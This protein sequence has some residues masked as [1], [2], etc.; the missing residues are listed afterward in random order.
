LD[1]GKNIQQSI[2][3]YLKNFGVL[4]LAGLVT[5]LI[6]AFSFGILA[7][8]M[9]A[10]LLALSFKLLRG[11]KGEFN[12]IFAHFNKFVPTFLL[13]LMLAVVWILTSVIG[14]IPLIGFLFQLAVGPAL[15]LIFML[16]IAL[17][18][19]KD[20]KPLDALKQGLNYF[21]TNPLMNWLYSLVIGILAGVGGIAG[22][23]LG[24][25]FIFIMPFISPFFV[26][27]GCAITFPVLSVG[28]ALAYQELSA[29]TDAIPMKIEKQTLQIVG[30]VVACLFVLGLAGR[31]FWGWGSLYSPAA[32]PFGSRT[33]IGN[34]GVAK[35]KIG[36]KTLSV[37]QELPADYPKD[38]PIYPKAQV[39]GFLAGSDGKVEGSTSTFTTK[40]SVDEI[41]AYY[42][43]N[44]ASQGWEVN[45]SEL[46]N[47]V[48]FT[49][50]KDGRDGGVTINPR[51]NKTTDILINVAK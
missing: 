22:A 32:G 12:E 24:A 42:E 43:S 27:A 28:M 50:K 2:N 35:I 5:V 44:L 49:M 3:L 6:S 7:G 11:E 33:P 10:G 19:E 13:V 46:G 20:L 37:S 1:I 36:G 30:I 47:M 29:K 34:H 39:T 8:P 16:A 21:L 25:I 18:V 48:V 4:C 51:E 9:I 45:K 38:I 31:F 15:F 40:N 17:V 26:L 23:I 14:F 41:A